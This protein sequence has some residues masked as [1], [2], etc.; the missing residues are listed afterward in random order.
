MS[1][2]VVADAHLG[3]QG[4]EAAALVA[5]L[6]ELSRHNCERLVLL[7]DLFQAWLGNPRFE[8][9]AIAAVTRALKELKGRGVRLDYIEGNRDFFIAGSAYETLFDSIGEELR[10]DL[11]KKRFL[12]VHGDGINRADR[13]YRFWR[14]VSKSRVVRLGTKTL[15]RGLA[16]TL[17]NWFER[18][19]S[20]TNFRHKRRLPIEVIEEYARARLRE[21]HDT[22]LLGHFHEPLRLRLAEGEVI[23]FDA[24]FR[25]RRIEWLEDDGVGVRA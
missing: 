11:G 12:A 7:G 8:T 16:L 14:R 25:S 20:R 10:F 5:Q 24:W 6:E 1:V 15:P 19:L 18:Q 17:M 3:G 13:L 22:V 2:A 21:G 4:G 9:A 23:V